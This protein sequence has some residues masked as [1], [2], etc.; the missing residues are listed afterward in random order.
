MAK[1]IRREGRAYYVQSGLKSTRTGFGKQGF[2][3]AL[4]LMRK[5]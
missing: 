1:K 2:L 3:N 5:K 4:K